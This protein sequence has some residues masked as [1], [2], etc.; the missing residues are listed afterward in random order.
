MYDP[1]SSGSAPLLNADGI[2]L[3]TEKTKVLNRLADHFEYVLNRPSTITDEA[4]DR[5]EQ[6]H[7]NH[8]MDISPQDSEVK[9]SIAQLP[10]EKAHRADAVPSDVF[11]AADTSII[12][13]L[14]KIFHSF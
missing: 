6:V 5:L 9:Q 13:Q 4:I 7:I 11:K 14:T 2:T 12:S 3:I 10:R 1:Q 8:D